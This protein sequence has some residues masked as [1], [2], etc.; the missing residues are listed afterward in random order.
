MEEREN[1]SKKEMDEE[2]DEAKQ[3]VEKGENTVSALKDK[4]NEVSEERNNRRC[5]NER[6]RGGNQAE[7][8]GDW[9][10]EETGNEA[11]VSLQ[12]GLFC[13]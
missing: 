2:I 4:L 13:D 3:G 1:L 9:N 11:V 5:Q 10:D 7:S 12:A 6:E 8:A